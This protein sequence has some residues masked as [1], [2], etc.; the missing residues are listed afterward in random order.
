MCAAG[1]SG[2]QIFNLTISD[3]AEENTIETLTEFIH[4][5]W[6]IFGV[7]VLFN[8]HQ[9]EVHLKQYASRLREEVASTSAQ[10]DVTYST[11]FCVLEHIT[12]RPSSLDPPPV[13]IIVY[14]ENSNKKENHKCIYKGVLLSWRN[15]R[16]NI[17]TFSNSVR[18]PLLLCRG[19]KNITQIVHNVLSRM[20]DCMFMTLPAREDDLLWLVPI[21]ISPIGEGNQ[22]KSTHEISLHYK[23]PELETDDGITVTFPVLDLVKILEEIMK[24]QDDEGSEVSFK[25][26]HIEKFREVLYVQMLKVASL[27]LGFCTLWKITLPAITIVENR[28]K[29]MNTNIMNR[30]LLY[31]N[32]KALDILHTI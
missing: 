8:F 11:E 22:P 31:L 24:D 7:S 21:V 12:P 2:R 17:L 19:G 4:K 5:T 16:K 14:A 27:Q 32:E 26:D 28:M 9:D 3:L 30:V 29:V 25:A 10:E 13:Q 23:I 1:I 20:F 6:T 18:L 15:N